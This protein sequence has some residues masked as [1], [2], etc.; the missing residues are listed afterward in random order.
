ML[1]K[2]LRWK[3]HATPFVNG[4]RDNIVVRDKSDYGND[5]LPLTV[6]TTPAFVE[7]CKIGRQGTDFSKAFG[8]TIV[9]D[10]FVKPKS[11][12]VCTW[13]KI[14]DRIFAEQQGR[15][16]HNIY[17]NNDGICFSSELM[18]W[19]KNSNG[20]QSLPFNGAQYGI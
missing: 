3:E 8:K 5:S 14:K 16:G 9:I 13:A 4:T 12:T 6:S 19:V 11:F 7:D 20:R 10:N 18:C 17:T 15:T 1:G 2:K